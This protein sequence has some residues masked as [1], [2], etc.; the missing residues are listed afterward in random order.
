MSRNAFA[1]VLPMK[2]SPRIATRTG[3]CEAMATILSDGARIAA[4][5][6]EAGLKPLG[7]T[8]SVAG[9]GYGGGDGF[10]KS[11]FENCALRAGVLDHH[12]AAVI[13]HDFLH[14]GKTEADAGFFVGADEGLEKVL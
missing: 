1:W 14:H 13:L 12:F 10:R 4:Q 6:W 5:Y 11:Q 3:A 7:A 9:V 8:V 2:P